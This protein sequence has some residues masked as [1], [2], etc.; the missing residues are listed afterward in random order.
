MKRH[1]CLLAAV[2]LLS[3]A[4]ALAPQ[5]VAR[6]DSLVT[7][8]GFAAKLGVAVAGAVA[9]PALVAEPE[10]ARAADFDVESTGVGADR[11]AVFDNVPQPQ[12]MAMPGK[13]DVNSA[14]VTEYKQLKGLYPAV[15]GKVASHGPYASISDVYKLADFSPAEAKLFKQHQGDFTVLPPGRMFIERINQRQSL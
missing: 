15:A 8:K 9:L 1:Q 6:A 3:A 4:D 14:T 13:L 10:R 5:L 7:R 2:A 12:Q 11:N